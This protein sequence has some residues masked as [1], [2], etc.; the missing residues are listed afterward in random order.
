M[1][2]IITEY[3]LYAFEHGFTI[4]LEGTSEGWQFW[5]DD[6]DDEIDLPLES[7]ISPDDAL[8]AIAAWYETLVFEAGDK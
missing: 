4:H 8:K 7:Y 1:A 6:L 3:V 2:L 5:A